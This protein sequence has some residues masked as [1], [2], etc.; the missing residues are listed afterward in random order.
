MEID[1]YSASVDHD[2]YFENSDDRQV[3]IINGTYA[4]YFDWVNEKSGALEIIKTDGDQY[5]VDSSFDGDDKSKTKD[6]LKYLDSSMK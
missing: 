2:D 4:E 5:I 3:K 1:S 6:C